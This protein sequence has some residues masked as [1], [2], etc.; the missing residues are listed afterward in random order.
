MKLLRLPP[1]RLR[2]LMNLWPPFAFSGIRILHLDPDGWSATV[3][4]RQYPWNG[5]I[6]GVHFGGSLFAMADPFWMTLLLRHLGRDH[7]VWDR[8]AE[9]EFLKPGRGDVTTRFRL[10]PEDVQRLRAA[11]ADGSKVLEWFTSEA[12]D[13]DG[14]V[15]ARVR[16]QVYVRRKDAAKSARPGPEEPA[17]QADRP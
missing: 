8:A 12:V 17:R 16:K 5:N 4:L 14:A 1:H 13:A 10:T 9:I 15:V 6:A 2:L 3:R 7:V 11:A